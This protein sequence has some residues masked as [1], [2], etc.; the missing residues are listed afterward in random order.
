MSSLRFIEAPP[1]PAG[2]DR[3]TW[4]SEWIGL[5]VGLA[6]VFPMTVGY[7]GEGKD[8]VYDPETK[9]WREGTPKDGMNTITDMLTDPMWVSREALIHSCQHSLPPRPTILAWLESEPQ[10]GKK[11]FAVPD[12]VAEYL[13]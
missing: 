13:P 12:A 4:D 9:L 6:S 10:V 1:L 11:V 5:H 2:V 7:L 8:R 3:K